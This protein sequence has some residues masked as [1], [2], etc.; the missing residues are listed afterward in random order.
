[1]QNEQSSISEIDLKDN[2]TPPTNPQPP[3]LSTRRAVHVAA[4]GDVRLDWLF[5]SREPA[6]QRFPAS[7]PWTRDPA[8]HIYLIPGGAWFSGQMLQGAIKPETFDKTYQL[9]TAPPSRLSSPF[10][11]IILSGAPILNP[12]ATT[13]VEIRLEIP[14][15]NTSD[16]TQIDIIINDIIERSSQQ[17]KTL[18]IT[19]KRQS[20]QPRTQLQVGLTYSRANLKS[21]FKITPG[22]L[23]ADQVARAFD[24][25]NLSFFGA[26]STNLTFLNIANSATFNL[27]IEY[28]NGKSEPIDATSLSVISN[29]LRRGVYDPYSQFVAKIN[30]LKSLAITNAKLEVIYGRVRS[31]LKMIDKGKTPPRQTEPDEQNPDGSLNL[32]VATDKNS[33][34]NAESTYISYQHPGGAALN[35]VPGHLVHS[36]SELS[37][38]PGPASMIKGAKVFRRARFHGIDGPEHG[39]PT[40]L[41][42]YF[43]S[44]SSKLAITQWQN[45]SQNDTKIVFIDDEGLGFSKRWDLWMPY[46]APSH[47]LDIFKEQINDYCS[48]S[49]I[50]LLDSNLIADDIISHNANTW[51]IV[52][53][54]HS[55]DATGSSLFQFLNKCKAQSRTIV[56]VSGESLRTGFATSENRPGIKLSKTVSWE[57]TLDDFQEAAKR[58]SLDDLSQVGHLIV[59]FGLEGAIY[60][61]KN[62]TAT[63]TRLFFDP[64]YI[65]NEYS[66]PQIFGSL[67]GLSTVLSSAV[68][69]S[70]KALLDFEDPSDDRVI[71]TIED[72]VRFGLQAARRYSELGFGPSIETV[73][74]FSRLHLPV[75]QIFS[76]GR[77]PVLHGQGIHKF[78]RFEV[79][80]NAVS[81]SKPDEKPKPL[82]DWS[83]L[84][85]SIRAA[86][87][88]TPRKISEYNRKL[89]DPDDHH[90]ALADAFVA[91]SLGRSIVIHGVTAA[92]EGKDAAIPYM[93]CGDLIAVD[94]H[95]IEGLRSIRSILAEYHRNEQRHSPISVAVFGP[96][97]SGKSYGVMQIAKTVLGPVLRT[98]TI[99]LAQ[100][101]SFSDLSR[102]LIEVREASKD[103]QVPLV[104]F[105]EFDCDLGEKPLGWL[106][107]FLSPMQ[108]G[109]FQYEDRLLTIGRAMFVFAGG[110]ASSHDEFNDPKF[111]SSRFVGRGEATGFN[112][113]KGPDF[114]SRLRGFLNI[115]GPNPTLLDPAWKDKSDDPGKFDRFA[116]EDF[117]FVIRRA[118]VIRQLLERMHQSSTPILDSWGC[119]DIDQDVLDALLLTDAYI[120]GVRSIQAVF[121]MS[122]IHGER[123]LSK[124]ALPSKEHL[125]M[126]VHRSFY[127]ILR[128]EYPSNDSGI[129]LELFEMLKESTDTE[130]VS[131]TL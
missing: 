18:T 17:I 73:R 64:K 16:P 54:S 39:Y 110:I 68:A 118:V 21:Q 75:S 3:S 125:L 63:T 33:K 29:S 82:A 27:M 12:I 94:R 65:E 113:A 40:I 72:G 107:F 128:R 105:D 14:E 56:I 44:D 123:S 55:I 62:E 78:R 9:I 47:Q 5:I 66:D 119:I 20:T 114:H 116:T 8:A 104:F 59:R 103:G 89:R 28:R 19:W 30:P 98:I 41:N 109:T 88:I 15:P 97:G 48:T 42:H 67:P 76:R 4:I 45:I 74:N 101:E 84:R 100:C 131:R 120:H 46:L 99:N 126:H 129:I 57:K 32:I 91:T 34:R 37:R 50:N 22:H 23:L 71:K 6:Q 108:D 35:Q 80:S 2:G 90:N 52:K 1:M 86:R 115:V 26:D 81:A 87:H 58:G 61:S 49:L 25:D 38:Y 85:E 121:E 95:E 112:S 117:T 130:S 106:R 127:T 124:T 11:Q 77:I 83:I 24:L 69:A 102:L 51:F 60:R 13:D 10:A 111:W 70:L 31:I 7:R 122:N 53:A 93:T 36:L 43:T 96:P 92:F 79:R